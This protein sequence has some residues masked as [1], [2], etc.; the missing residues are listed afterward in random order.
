M[1]KDPC[2][3]GDPEC[4]R[5]FDQDYEYDSFQL[6]QL[7]DDWMDKYL[8]SEIDKAV[9]RYMGVDALIDCLETPDLLRK[10]AD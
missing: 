3:C 9:E 2:L 7:T 5:C 8:D 10:Q 4:P 1:T 6:D